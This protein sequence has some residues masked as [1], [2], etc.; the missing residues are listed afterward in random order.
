M[1]R[2]RWYTGR[3]V[4]R[5]KKG[6]VDKEARERRSK[7]EGVIANIGYRNWKRNVQRMRKVVAV[8]DAGWLKFL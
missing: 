6:K 1:E 2:P 3:S 4:K 5:Q 7:V 8:T